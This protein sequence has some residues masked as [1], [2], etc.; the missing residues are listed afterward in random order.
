MSEKNSSVNN[1]VLGSMKRWLFS[2]NA[3]D[4]AILYILFSI[5]AGLIGTSL[6]III[7]LELARTRGKISEWSTI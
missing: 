3:K 1:G 4:V 6:S 7:R 2:T 5:I